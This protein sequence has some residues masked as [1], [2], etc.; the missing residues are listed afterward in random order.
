MN[1]TERKAYAWL[2]K[3]GYSEKDI[4]FRRRETPDFVLSNGKTY[5][6]KRLYGK[7]TVWFTPSQLESIKAVNA[8]VLVFSDEM[9]EPVITIPSRK[10]IPNGIVGGVKITV[11]GEEEKTLKIDTRLHY[12][13]KLEAVKRGEQLKELIERILREWL[14]RE[15]SEG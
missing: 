4:V 11:A 1:R 5:E 12:D 13:L 3:Q 2:L 6:A 10:L 7:S 15:A 8:T 14:K 9:D